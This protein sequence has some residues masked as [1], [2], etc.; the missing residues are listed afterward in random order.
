MIGVKEEIS[1]GKCALVIWRLCEAHLSLQLLCKRRNSYWRVK[2]LRSLNVCSL[3]RYPHSSCQQLLKRF[4]FPSCLY[5]QFLNNASVTSYGSNWETF[6]VIA[7]IVWDF[8][9]WRHV[10]IFVQCV[11]LCSAGLGSAWFAVFWHGLIFH[12]SLLSLQS[13]WDYRHIV[14]WS[15]SVFVFLFCDCLWLFGFG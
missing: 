11:W 9:V 7:R 2:S 5:F 10:W 14:I 15:S 3:I 1:P 6:E 4:C 8:V 13:E 12:C